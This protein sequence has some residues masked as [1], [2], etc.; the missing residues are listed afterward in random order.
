MKL[1]ILISLIITAF[2]GFHADAKSSKN[3]AINN[4][5]PSKVVVM[6]EFTPALWQLIP[7]PEIA[8]TN[9]L[10]RKVGSSEFAEGQFITLHGKITDSSCVPISDAIVEIWQANSFGGVNY[11]PGLKKQH[12]DPNFQSTG[13]M[14]TDNEGQYSF[15]T[16]LPGSTAKNRAPSINIRVRHK[17]FLPLETVIYFENQPLNSKDYRLTK[18]ISK[19]NMHL[20]VAKEENC[21]TNDLGECIKYSFNITLEGK[22]LYKKY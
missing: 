17:D 4:N 16:I 3:S 5:P 12:L 2:L 18:E 8:K 22:N 19:K 20:L 14:I 7:P 1:T 10:R 6:C 9:N 15:A 13:S 11:N 21:I